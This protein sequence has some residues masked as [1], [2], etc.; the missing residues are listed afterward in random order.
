M[1]DSRPVLNARDARE[2]FDEILT[3]DDL[4]AREIDLITW[5][6]QLPPELI[7]EALSWITE[8]SPV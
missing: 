8:I 1:V 6:R 3:T 4:M 7:P 2:R 5:S